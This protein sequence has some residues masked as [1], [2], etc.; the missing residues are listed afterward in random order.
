MAYRPLFDD[1]PIIDLDS[2]FTELD[3]DVTFALAGIGKVELENRLLEVR[4]LI[5][6]HEA[7]I[8]AAEEHLEEL[9]AELRKY[10]Q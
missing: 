2:P 8:A 5:A 3:I 9:E 1:E 7:D 10:Q 4:A 6:K